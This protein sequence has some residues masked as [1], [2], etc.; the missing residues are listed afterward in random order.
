MTPDL[1][2]RIQDLAERAEKHS[3]KSAKLE[4]KMHVEADRIE[5]DLLLAD[6]LALL[7]E[8]RTYRL[9]DGNRQR[10]AALRERIKRRIAA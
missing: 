3:E 10:V 4:A 5:T 1:F 7:N 9:G 8:I 6:T 2:D